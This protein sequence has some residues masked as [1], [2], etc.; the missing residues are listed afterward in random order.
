MAKTYKN[1]LDDGYT[2]YH[3]DGTTSVSYKNVL[4]NGTTTYHSDGSTSVTYDNVLDHGTTTYHSDGSTSRTY[5][6]VL[7]PGYTT[8]HS[9]GSQSVTYKNM[10]DPGYTTYET[11]PKLP[12][13]SAPV[14]KPKRT[15]SSG[16]EYRTSMRNSVNLSSEEYR[17]KNLRLTNEQME[18][19][20]VYA[21]ALLKS[22]GV[23]TAGE[24]TYTEY[25]DEEEKYGF[26]NLKTR[27]V[28]K[29]RKIRGEA[30]WITEH[31]VKT[32]ENTGDIEEQEEITNE[33]ITVSG[34]FM[35]EKIVENIYRTGRYEKAVHDFD[36]EGPVDYRVDLLDHFLKQHGID[37][38]VSKYFQPE[39]QKKEAPVPRRTERGVHHLSSDTYTV[40]TAGL[41]AANTHALETVKKLA[42]LLSIDDSEAKDIAMKRKNLE[43]GNL[44]KEE[45]DRWVKML[46]ETGLSVYARGDVRT[47]K[48]KT[49]YPN[50]ACPCG[51]G[52][53]YR[54]CHGK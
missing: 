39:E 25:Y 21:A 49:I 45:A 36:K 42:Q 34:R 32:T 17:A 16:G 4:N 41:S 10:L 31:H 48:D 23:R 13:Y 5:Q 7:D 3:D 40:V 9:D 22:K 18:E 33:I 28:R 27:K 43:I 44:T 29:S 20:A 14:P 30:Y 1:I 15:G 19:Y 52:K 38:N 26:L 46:R 51:S 2:T 6:N 11:K 37:M 24:I 47:M 8:Y 50:D 35:R 53:K 12:V 54:D